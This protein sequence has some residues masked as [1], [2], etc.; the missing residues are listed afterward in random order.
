MF[1]THHDATQPG[2]GLGV[3]DYDR[4]LFNPFGPN[5]EYSRGVK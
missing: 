4:G 2:S 5:P 3:D 1:C